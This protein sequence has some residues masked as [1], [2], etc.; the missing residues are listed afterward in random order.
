MNHWT[1]NAHKLKTIAVTGRL[2]SGKTCLSAQICD[3]IKENKPVFFFKHPNPELISLQEFEVV[4]EF[5]QIE[6]LQD[7][8]L[9]IDEP[10]LFIKRHENKANAALEALMTLCRQRNIT[11]IISTADT[12]FFTRG[13]ESYVDAWCILDIDPFLVKQGSIIKKILKA[14]THITLEE[15]RLPK[16]WYIFHSREFFKQNGKY[17][18]VKPDW[19]TEEW[20]TPFRIDLKKSMQYETPRFSRK[21]FYHERKN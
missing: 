15:F 10:Q 4:Y 6:T 19:Y 9:Y 1:N 14:N 17:P 16:G 18:F 13:I 8:C 3:V 11:L 7:C 12:R 20:S 5:G 21:R 2:G